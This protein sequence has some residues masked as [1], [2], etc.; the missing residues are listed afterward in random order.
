MTLRRVYVLF[1]LEVA[2]RDLHILEVTAG[3]QLCHLPLL[4]PAARA[5]LD[6]GFRRPD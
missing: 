6:V 4:Q 5:P 2:D 1:A 3:F